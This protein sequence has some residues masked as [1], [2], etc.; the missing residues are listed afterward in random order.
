[1]TLKKKNEPVVTEA[2]AAAIT[3][4]SMLDRAIASG[5]SV[6]VLERLMALQE[7]W[8]ANEARRSFSAAL[9]ALRSDMPRI[10]KT[11][12]VKFSST[13]YQYEDLAEIV[14]AVSGPMAQHGLSFR[15]RTDSDTPGMVKVTCLVEHADGHSE[16]TALSGPYDDSG[17]KNAIQAIGSV[18]TYLQRY[19][20]K[21]ALG[22]AAARDDDGRHGA[23]QGSPPPIEAPQ[24]PVQAR[25]PVT[26]RVAPKD[27]S[28]IIKKMR[29]SLPPLLTADQF[30]AAM[31]QLDI[32]KAGVTDILGTDLIS[33]VE[34]T[35][36]AT[37]LS[38]LEIVLTAL[39]DKLS[40]PDTLDF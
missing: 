16:A 36:N 34:L 17:N 29:G 14:D 5:A 30:D 28:S 27:Y 1:L 39:E 15:W 19:T 25:K 37:N 40:P 11:Q 3:P 2:L 12:Q 32:P 8:Q 10:V 4:M 26:P 20:L 18:V 7:R 31:E 9:A 22:I 23:P 13:N 35:P 38:A 33:Y 21:A 24:R 6:E